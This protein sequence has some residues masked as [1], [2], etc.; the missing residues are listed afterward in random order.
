M[1]GPYFIKEDPMPLNYEWQA[2]RAV[3]IL[4]ALGKYQRETVLGRIVAWLRDMFLR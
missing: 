1:N 4:I 3:A 2:T